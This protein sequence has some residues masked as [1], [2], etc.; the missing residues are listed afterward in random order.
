MNLAADARDSLKGLWCYRS[1]S[2]YS[3]VVALI[4]VM[5]RGE[6]HS[7]NGVAKPCVLHE[8]LRYLCAFIKLR[9]LPCIIKTHFLLLLILA[10]CISVQM[11]PLCQCHCTS[12]AG[13]VGEWAESFHVMYH[14]HLT[15]AATTAA[16]EFQNDCADPCCYA[17]TLHCYT[18]L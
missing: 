2:E 18:Q 3:H 11:L 8:Q 5:Y 15:A 17:N 16:M 4:I 10:C 12:I 1:Q 6:S 14:H 7:C 9:N 13:T